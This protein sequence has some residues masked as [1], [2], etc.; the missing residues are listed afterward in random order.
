[1]IVGR[2]VNGIGIGFVSSMSPVYLSECASSRIRGMLL[3]VGACCNVGCFCIANW[4]A[5]GL[6][7]DN[8]AFQWRFPLAFQLIFFFLIVPILCMVP[9][10]PRWL[11][12]MDR[13]EEALLVLSRLAGHVKSVE[14]IIVTNEFN[15]IKAAIRLEREDAV[16]LMDVLCHRDK[17]QNFRR[18]LLGCGTQFMQQFRYL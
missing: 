7:H 15:S 5:Y 14:D 10:S 13:E 6:A 8:S 2:L 1:M 17:V 16:P 3:A 4:I 12:L 9:E 18:L 11:L